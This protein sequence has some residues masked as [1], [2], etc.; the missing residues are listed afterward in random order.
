MKAPRA[1]GL[2]AAQKNENGTRFC[3]VKEY[4]FKVAPELSVVQVSLQT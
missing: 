1:N 3:A 2:S 4:N